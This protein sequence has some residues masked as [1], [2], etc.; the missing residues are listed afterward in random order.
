MSRIGTMVATGVWS[1]L[2]YAGAAS[3]AVTLPSPILFVTQVPVGGF[4]T[5]TSTF[6]AQLADMQSAP[7]GGDL[8]IRYPDGTLRNLTK[9]AGYGRSTIAQDGPAAIAVRQP[10]V[11]W[12]GDKALFAMV[13]GAPSRQYEVLDFR[14]QIYEVTGLAQGQPARI[15]RLPCQPAEYNNIAPTY[16]SD[17]SVLF[18]SD[19]PRNGA[20]HLYPQRDEYESAP[21]DTGIWQI[22]PVACTVTILQHA[23]SGVS[24]P[25]V[26]SAGHV[27]F[28]KWDHLQ[29]DQQAD[30]DQFEGGSYGSFDYASE[31]AQ[32]PPATHRRQEVFPE[33]R[34]AEYSMGAAFDEES[35]AP[36]YPFS[37]HTFNQFMPWSINQDGSDEELLHH[38]GRHELGGTYTEG[39]FRDDPALGPVTAGQFSG[40]TQF[41]RGDG[42]MFHLREDPNRPG[43]YWGVRAPEFASATA[44][45]LL[46]F[47]ARP[48]INTDRIKLRLAAAGATAGRM[49]NPLPL[50][51]GQLV[52]VR[53]AQAGLLVRSGTSASPAYNYRFRLHLMNPDGARFVPGERLTPGIAREVAYWDPDQR[54][55][56]SGTLW[57]L[58]PVEVRPRPLPPLTRMPA[59]QD[60]ERQAFAAAGVNAPALRRWL[61]NRRLALIVSRNVTTR[62]RADIQQ[63]FNLRVGGALGGLQTLGDP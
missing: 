5:L 33:L 55:S 51:D 47:D 32:T 52:A 17:D 15:A 25:S 37:G 27:I 3:A 31:S 48:E 46:F 45:D 50:S 35:I 49:R 12:S 2:A 20:P 26:D 29:R 34:R 61:R 19:R 39:N 58:D 14:W 28:T 18:V 22:D 44:G 30:A 23:P 24:Y 4:T 1:A 10:S 59:L 41:L 60:P 43:R 6:G 38:L 42:G 40:A 53:T 56:W 63:P 54:V 57:E 13:E 7:R 62:D 36:D 11:H 16:G 21:I 9:E 8:W